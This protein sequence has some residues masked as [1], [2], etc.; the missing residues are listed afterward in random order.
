MILIHEQTI[1]TSLGEVLKQRYVNEFAGRQT[2]RDLDTLAQ[3]QM[4]VQGMAGKRL[5]YQDLVS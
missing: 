5:Q 4:I 2:C 3:M 1:S